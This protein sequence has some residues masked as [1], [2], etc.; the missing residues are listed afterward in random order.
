MD[1]PASHLELGAAGEGAALAHYLNVG[2]RELARG[3]RSPLGEIDL[4]IARAG[5]LVFCEVKTRR[6]SAFGGPFEA[7]GW[8]KQRK[9]RQVAQAFLAA[10]GLE[11]DGI[12]FDVA[13]VMV[14]ERG[15]PSVHVF[16]GAF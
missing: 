15:R 8:K 1:R 2:Y 12:R 5:T 6:G 10:S 14:D 9:L 4:V 13:S 7:V 11:P 3:W 16:E